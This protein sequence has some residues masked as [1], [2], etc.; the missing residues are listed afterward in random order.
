MRGN[1]LG[2]DKE[3]KKIDTVVADSSRRIILEGNS[4]RRKL[5]GGRGSFRRS[6]AE[7]KMGKSSAVALQGKKKRGRQK[8]FPSRLWTQ[9]GIKD[10]HNRD[11]GLRGGVQ[12]VT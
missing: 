5:R 10:T 12:G 1:P 9:E 6:V 2:S 4:A 11:G 3:K 7:P 8:T